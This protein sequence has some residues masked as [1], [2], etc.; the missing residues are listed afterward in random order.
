MGKKCVR[1]GAVKAEDDF[2][3]H[4]RVCTMC[5]VEQQVERKRTAPVRLNHQLLQNWGRPSETLRDAEG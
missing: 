3:E 2:Y 4:R 1:C 5:V